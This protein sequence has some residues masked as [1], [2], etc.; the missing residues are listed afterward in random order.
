MGAYVVFFDV[1]FGWVLCEACYLWGS[2]SEA[3]WGVGLAFYRQG[4]RLCNLQL[5]LQ[6]LF[7]QASCGSNCG[8]GGSSLH[9]PK[10]PCTQIVH[11]L[12]PMYLY[13]DYFKANVYTI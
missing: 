1:F 12:A 6:R 3:V 7:F 4:L 11:T 2:A 8:V 10:G 5:H 9:Y 13:R